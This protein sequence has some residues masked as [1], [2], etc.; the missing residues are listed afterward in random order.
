MKEGTVDVFC[1]GGGASG[2]AHNSS[3]SSTGYGAGGGSGYT[4]TMK[5]VSLIK[6]ASIAI[7]IGASNGNTIFGGLCIAGRGNTAL[8]ENVITSSST[9]MYTIGGSGGS[10]GGGA[11]GSANTV[12]GAGGSDGNAGSTSQYS[13]GRGQNKTTRAFEESGNTLYAGAGGGGNSNTGSSGNGGAGGGGNGGNSKLK[14]TDGIA[15]TGGG[16]G[17]GDYVYGAGAGGSGICI[18]RCGF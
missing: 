16:G 12:G 7:T 11:S 8:A 9:D 2:T 17:G 13:G 6:H 15:N 18:V 5:N 10:G 4:N 14:G 1:V 3:A